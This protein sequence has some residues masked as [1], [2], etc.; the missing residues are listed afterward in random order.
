MYYKECVS[1]LCCSSAFTCHTTHYTTV[2]PHHTPHNLSHHH[3]PHPTIP[4]PHRTWSKSRPHHTT[5]HT[6]HKPTT[7]QSHHTTL[8]PDLG[9][10]IPQYTSTPHHTPPRQAHITEHLTTAHRT[11]TTP[12]FNQA[13]SVSVILRYRLIPHSTLPKLLNKMTSMTHW[14][15][16]IK[17][18]KSR[19]TLI[20]YGYDERTAAWINSVLS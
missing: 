1:A 11:Y 4:Q 3:V 20:I 9:L 6:T 18:Y 12:R 8:T 14:H 5:R 2:T 16:K 15:M 13:T 17:V 19:I 10:T 7:P